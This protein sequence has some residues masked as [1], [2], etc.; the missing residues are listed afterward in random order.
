VTVGRNGEN[1]TL[2]LC[3]MADFDPSFPLEPGDTGVQFTLPGDFKRS[4]A[5]FRANGV[6]FDQLPTKETWGWWASVVDPDGN[7]IMLVPS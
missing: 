5:A 7:S 6:Q 2:H 1:G 3:R 4:C